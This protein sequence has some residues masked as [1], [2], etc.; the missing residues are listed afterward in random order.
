VSDACVCRSNAVTNLRSPINIRVVE[1]MGSFWTL[2]MFG[3]H[4]RSLR[5]GAVFCHASGANI[6]SPSSAHFRLLI[7]HANS[8]RVGTFENCITDTRFTRAELYSNQITQ[9]IPS[10]KDTDFLSIPGAGSVVHPLSQPVLLC[11]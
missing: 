7:R 1:P 5:L 4:L 3:Q 10:L 8:S 11:R 2:S 6:I 9:V